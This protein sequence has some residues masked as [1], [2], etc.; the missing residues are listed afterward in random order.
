MDSQTTVGQEGDSLSDIQSYLVNFN[1]EICSGNQSYILASS[2]SQKSGQSEFVV[3]SAGDQLY[4]GNLINTV[5][6]DGMTVLKSHPVSEGGGSK[7]KA[8]AIQSEQT[9]L[10]EGEV[11][12]SA[13]QVGTETLLAGESVA[14]GGGVGIQT[15]RLITI[16]PDGS[17][18]DAQTPEDADSNQRV[19]EMSDDQQ[20]LTVQAGDPGNTED[21]EEK[22]REQL[23]AGQ[24][25]QTVTIV[26][27]EVDQGGEVS[28]VLIVSQN[29]QQAK[30]DQ[31][32]NVDMSVYD[33]KE[34]NRLTADSQDVD[35]SRRGLRSASKKQNVQMVSQ[36]MCN[37][38]NYT[39]P[40]KYLLTRHMKTHSDERPHKCHICDRGFKTVASLQNH[41]NTH[42]GVHPHKCKECDAAFTTS[43]ELVRHVRYRHTYE[44]PHKCPECDYASVELSKL[45]RHMRSHTGE[46]PYQCPHCTYASPDTYKLKR[47]LRIHTGEKPY[48][49]DFCHTRFTQSNSLKA[50]RLI[51][52]GNKPVYQCELCPTTCSRKTDLKFH[53]Q[54]LHTSDTP[55][56]CKKCGKS[57][58]DRYTW[59][60]HIK[61]HEGEKCFKCEL[62]PYAALSQRHLESHLLTH[63]GEKPFE[64]D[65][66]ELSFRQKQLLKRHK[67][68]YHNPDYVPPAPKDKIH[69]CP[70]CD[71]AFAHRGNLLRHRMSH[72]PENME[73]QHELESYRAERGDDYDEE[74]EEEDEDQD[75]SLSDQLIVTE[76]VI[77]DGQAYE[78]EGGGQIHLA[79]I[80]GQQVQLQLVSLNDENN[81]QV[82]IQI[83]NNQQLGLVQEQITNGQQEEIPTAIE[84][85]TP[86]EHR[87]RVIHPSNMKIKQENTK[88]EDD[89]HTDGHAV[90]ANQFG[91]PQR[92]RRHDG[93]EAPSK[94]LRLDMEV[95]EDEN[96]KK[97][98]WKKK[99]IETCF[100][101]DE[102]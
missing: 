16:Q 67:N 43:G 11:V 31:D 77:G 90:V 24:N 98:E 38:C 72:D 2:G 45:K 10:D 28:Y 12:F 66:C 93:S 46:R 36:L 84:I 91:T 51:H 86:T 101:F 23:E 41:I 100:G 68:L 25:Y 58:P 64:C 57:F 19:I 80:N 61:T 69:E 35:S 73:Y 13:H 89:D 82:Y 97:K 4:D 60:L 9:L 33:F 52:T 15:P 37:Y 96:Q 20:L 7:L 54:K 88:L 94:R 71:K 63:T 17:T 74:A 65:E 56:Q 55:V 5:V 83:D 29:D 78:R 44:K 32:G 62:C 99:D 53:V 48:E 75:T 49:C 30:A 39:S 50:H 14:D 59:K 92:T 40:K 6:E 79:N 85:E 3:T 102:M 26:P 42:T 22:S 34:E 27:S 81:T 95:G 47:H 18:T 76:A 87:D 1:K 8:D 21:E 70:D